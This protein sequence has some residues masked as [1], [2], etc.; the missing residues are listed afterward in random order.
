[1]TRAER[2]T[3]LL[4]RIGRFLVSGGSAALLNLILLHALVAR[5][6]LHGGLR[7]NLANLAALEVSTLYQFAA[8]RAW[9]W[10]RKGRSSVWRDLAAFHGAI[11]TTALVRILLYALLERVGVHHLI[12]ATVGIGLVAIANFLLYDRVVFS[13]AP[14]AEQ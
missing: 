7:E 6:G 5:L 1:M 3:Q 8:C 9:V 4:A 14:K 11:A 2:R 13:A 12:N 10:S